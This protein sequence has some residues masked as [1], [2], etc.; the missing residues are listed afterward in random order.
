MDVKGSR[1]CT[2]QEETFFRHP[3]SYYGHFE[4][5]VVRS[6]N[7]RTRTTSTFG[8]RDRYLEDCYHS[9]VPST[10]ER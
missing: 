3:S 4:N 2:R 5:Y 6:N 7:E 9:R 10:L 8:R 1:I